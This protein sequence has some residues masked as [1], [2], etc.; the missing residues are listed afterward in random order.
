MNEIIQ[1]G[2]APNVPKSVVKR[3]T[4]NRNVI[5]E[6]VYTLFGSDVACEWYG[7]STSVPQSNP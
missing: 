6:G 1:T 2:N 5:L 7:R 4:I 3:S